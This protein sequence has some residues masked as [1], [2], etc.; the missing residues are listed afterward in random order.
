MAEQAYPQRNVSPKASPDWGRWLYPS[1][2]FGG[3]LPCA[4][5]G[6]FHVSVT[7]RC[8][9]GAYVVVACFV[10]PLFV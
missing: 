6:A 9:T 8:G 1:L 7:T 10:R 3:T 2:T 5:V 4:P